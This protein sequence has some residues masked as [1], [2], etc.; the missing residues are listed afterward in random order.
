MSNIENLLRRYHEGS[1]A[2]DELSEL[3]QLTH[4]DRVLEAANRQAHTIHRRRRVAVL[5]M[6][7]VLAVAGTVVFTHPSVDGVMP[8]MPMV[9]QADVPRPI[10]ELSNAPVVKPVT[11]V[12]KAVAVP[13]TNTRQD[14]TAVIQSEPRLIATVSPEQPSSVEMV[15]EQ[16]EP[17]AT[18]DDPI[19]AC[20]TQCSPDSVINDIWKFLRT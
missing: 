17:S 8:D 14:D 9:A 12:A 20:N 13:T 6:V 1:I 19:V 3:N 10:E 18:F 2:P 7:A 5:G 16:M 11:N 4:R 15:V